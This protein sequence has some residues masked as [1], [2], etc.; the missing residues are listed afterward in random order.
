[1]ESRVE[2]VELIQGVTLDISALMEYNGQGKCRE[3]GCYKNTAAKY[4]DRLKTWVTSR[5]WTVLFEDL[6]VLILIS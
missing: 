3:V 2:K 4:K 6:D 5:N 1:M